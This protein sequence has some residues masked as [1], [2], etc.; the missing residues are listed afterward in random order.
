MELAY[1]MSRAQENGANSLSCAQCDAT[2]HVRST[3]Y[4]VPDD[5]EET[6][7]PES[8]DPEGSAEEEG[9]GR[10]VSGDPPEEG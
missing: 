10:E 7:R 6:E 5:P 3:R 9:R 1:Q 4:V 2:F 8:G